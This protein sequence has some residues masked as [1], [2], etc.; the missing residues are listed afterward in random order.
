MG[1]ISIFNNVDEAVSTINAKGPELMETARNILDVG[2]SLADKAKTFL[3]NLNE[4]LPSERSAE[5]FLKFTSF[6]AVS[7]GCCAIASILQGVSAQ[8]HLAATSKEMAAR[9][10]SMSVEIKGVSEAAQIGANMQYQTQFPQQVYN[11]VKGHSDRAA[12]SSKQ[13]F[14]FVYHPSD[15]WHG[16]FNQLLNQIGPLP[17][18]CGCTAN[19][20]L[21]I[22]FLPY[23]RRTIEHDARI[24]I[25]LP[26][27]HM[28]V[29][30]DVLTLPSSIGL[31]SMS[32]AW[33]HSGNPYVY[34][35]LKDYEA[36]S[37]HAVE[38]IQPP[39]ASIASCRK[40]GPL[41]KY[42]CTALAGVTSGIVG[43]YVSIA[44]IGI[45]STIYP[46]LGAV[47]FGKLCLAGALT[48]GAVCSTAASI[49]VPITFEG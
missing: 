35:T 24:H 41:S 34:L 17:G 29:L 33:H 23:F 38:R 47:L 13:E 31:L 3:E 19:M 11:F 42:T 2:E 9:L 5:L 48:G 18:F 43:A 4:R 36:V 49:Y 16:T 15:E 37:Y 12:E 32:G 20:T 46:P 44:G 1:I 28:Y 21:L 45:A 30:P 8:R 10:K 26:T 6:A 25:L 39:A 7:R 40:P 22:F 14:F 27:A